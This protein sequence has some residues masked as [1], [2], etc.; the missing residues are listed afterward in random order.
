[1]VPTNISHFCYFL[2][3][4]SFCPRYLWPYNE[5]IQVFSLLP[6]FVVVM[7]FQRDGVIILCVKLLQNYFW[8][9]HSQFL[10]QSYPKKS[11]P[12]DGGLLTKLHH[13]TS[14]LFHALAFLFLNCFPIV[15]FS[16]QIFFLFFGQ[17][18]QIQLY[19]YLFYSFFGWS[20]YDFQ[21]LV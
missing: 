19:F 10:D 14:L 12:I 3:T 15:K 5:D 2:V 18:D 11:G 17:K 16:C 6:I 1:M 21:T 4:T 7:V 13:G 20:R 9:G 8:V